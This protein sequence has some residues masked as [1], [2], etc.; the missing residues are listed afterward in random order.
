MPNVKRVYIAA[1][2]G[3]EEEAIELAK[4]L[5]DFDIRITYRW[6][7]LV[8]GDTDKDRATL[9]LEGVRECDLL[10]VLLKPNGKSKQQGTHVE[11]GFA[12]ACQKTIMIHVSNTEWL[13][14]ED[15]NSKLIFYELPQFRMS[16]KKTMK[17][18]A[19]QIYKYL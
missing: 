17:E 18:L 6:W 19:E 7:N 13:E 8:N 12:L 5:N 4:E 9:D 10:V 2:I 14:L 3:N 11:I 16:F 1:G 15:T